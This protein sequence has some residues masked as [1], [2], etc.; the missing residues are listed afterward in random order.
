MGN[1]NGGLNQFESYHLLWASS[2]TDGMFLGFNMHIS[3]ANVTKFNI[4]DYPVRHNMAWHVVRIRV[5]CCN[6][7]KKN[8]FNFFLAFTFNSSMHK[9]LRVEVI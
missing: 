1:R 2:V 4:N 9:E 5:L 6:G 7:H 3:I 8:I